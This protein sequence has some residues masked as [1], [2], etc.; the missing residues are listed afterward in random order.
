MPKPG[1]QNTVQARILKYR[2]NRMDDCVAS[3]RVFNSLAND[4]DHFLEE[5]RKLIALKI[6]EYCNVP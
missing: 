1:E 5:K 6:K 3:E 2:G 4:D